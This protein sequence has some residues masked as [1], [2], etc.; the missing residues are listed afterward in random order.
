[1]G[2]YLQLYLTFCLIG[3]TAFGG[4][5]AVLPLIQEYVV[6]AN[7]WMNMTEFVDLV[8]ISQMTPGPIAINSATFVGTKIAGLPGAIL[9]T[10]GAI[11]PQTILMLGL[12]YFLF[13]RE[14]KFLF[15]DKIL[16]AL[17]PGIVGLILIAALSMMASSLFDGAIGLGSINPV[18]LVTFVIGAILFA[19]KV[20]IIKIIGV[21]ALLGLV[22]TQIGL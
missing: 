22:L 11:T 21:G 3:A 4:G 7:G 2:L 13:V 16:M 19:K 8:S 17:R 20:D 10:L 12:G 6:E 1:M 5:Y 18:A 15:L 9:A 14:Q